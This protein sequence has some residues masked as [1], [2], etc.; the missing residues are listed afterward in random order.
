MHALFGMDHAGYL[1]NFEAG[2][3]ALLDRGHRVTVATDRIRPETRPIVA[4]LAA[5]GAFS[6]SEVPALIALPDA[7]GARVRATLDY[8]HYLRPDFDMTPALRKRARE[9]A[10]RLAVQ[11]GHA[12]PFV[13]RA[14]AAGL[15]SLERRRPVPGELVDFLSRSNPDVVLLT[16]LIYLESTQVLWIRAARRI[17]VPSVFC[18]HSWDNL[19]TKGTLHDMPT[20]VLVWNHAQ[21]AEA[22]ALHGVDK[23]RCAVTGATAFDHWFS[24]RPTMSRGEF[25]NSVGLPTGRKVLLYLCSSRFIAKG[26]DSWVEEWIRALRAAP[27]PAVRDA[28]V[29]VRPHPS[30]VA[31]PQISRL[32]DPAAR[33]FPDHTENPV[34]DE[35][36]LRYFHS[37]YHSD[38]VVG[39]N[40]TSMI[41]AAIL[42]KP[43]LSVRA[44]GSARVQQTVHFAHI[45]QGLLTVAP[46]LDT[47]VRQLSDVLHG[48]APVRR[49]RA[50][51]E[52]FVRPQG[53][54][55]PAGVRMAELV[56]ALV[57]CPPAARGRSGMSGGGFGRP[58][59]V[60]RA[61]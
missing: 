40:T 20:R 21:C 16:P 51:V 44:P 27:D 58:V 12:P 50:F 36:R 33:L 35:A 19:T 46:D 43:V 11:M 10:P 57:G 9:G 8:W 45:E 42:D 47:H 7:L 41:E 38:A 18:V 13:R 22:E 52:A 23:A 31:I 56:E 37:L 6:V 5:R 26:E 39:L 2:I 17:G 32:G 53:I 14:M 61:V 54:E 34:S 1:R 60:N 4:R 15:R 28:V 24:T 55:R 25:L 59:G 30:A 3:A 49:S 48:E 29:I